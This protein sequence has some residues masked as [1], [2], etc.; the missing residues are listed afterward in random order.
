M[1]EKGLH[2]KII[3]AGWWSP[4][5]KTFLAAQVVKVS[6]Q[7][8]GWENFSAASNGPGPEIWHIGETKLKQHNPVI[9][10]EHR[11]TNRK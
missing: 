10:L 2:N 4:K 5:E 8:F 3:T 9:V 1:T 6:Q 11:E 7:I